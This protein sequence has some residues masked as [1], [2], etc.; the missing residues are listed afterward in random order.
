VVIPYSRATRE[1]VGLLALPQLLYVKLPCHSYVIA[2]A[3]E[4]RSAGPGS[5]AEEVGA[6][7]RVRVD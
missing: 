3:K 5:C 4:Q 7:V 2:S 1:K 6:M